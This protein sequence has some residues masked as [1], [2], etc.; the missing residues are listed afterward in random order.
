MSCTFTDKVQQWKR[1]T[2]G[3]SAENTKMNDCFFDKK[4]WRQCRAEVR[5]STPVLTTMIV[6][7]NLN[8]QLSI[9]FSKH[10]LLYIGHC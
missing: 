3:Y 8:D 6:E 1:F 9:H 2:D 4:D 7:A 10:V 5:F